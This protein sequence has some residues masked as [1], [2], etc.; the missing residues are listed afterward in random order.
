V[1]V[2]VVVQPVHVVAEPEQVAQLA[3]QAVQ[4]VVLDW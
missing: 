2:P 3:L 1:A 4:A